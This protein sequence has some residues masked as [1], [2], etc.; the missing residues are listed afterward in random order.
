ME[1]P[2]QD[3]L[4]DLESVVVQ[5]LATGDRSSL[6]IIGFGEISIALGCPSVG[7]RVVCKR[8]APMTSAQL[9]H[10]ASLVA[11]YVDELGAEDVQ[12]APTTVMSVERGDVHIAYLVQP[13]LDASSLGHNILAAAE[14]SAD[15]PFVVALAETVAVA[16][17]RLSID[18]QV[19]NWSW[20]DEQ[21]TLI[22]V[23]T[24]FMWDHNGEPLLD[25]SPLS[26]MFPAP[27]R[28]VVVK[29]VFKVLNRWQTPQ[30]VGHDIVANLY[31]EGLNAWV[32]PVVEALNKTVGGSSPID[33]A[34]AHGYYIEDG[35]TFPRLKKMQQIERAWRTKVRRQPYDFF[36][37]ET[38]YA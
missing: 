31:R 37:Q 30:G 15:H 19:T 32:D 14:P 36:V 25:A 5:A 35:K 26:R 3:E 16:T 20:A 23:G 24:P 33:S 18:A 21:L 9:D 1:L 22:D 38:T 12:V 8:S 29:D 28:G 34:V 11:R 7:P 2:T 10:Y 17:D 4:N 6:N 13:L 27:L